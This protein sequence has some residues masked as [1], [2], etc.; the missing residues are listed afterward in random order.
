MKV[1]VATKWNRRAE[2]RE[3]M[4]DLREDGHAITHDWTGEE[5]PGPETDP[6]TRRE[7]YGMCAAADVDG[8]LS[9]EVMVLLHDPACRGAFVELGVALANGTRVIVVDGDG[10][11]EHSV[12]LFY[13]LPEVTHVASA[14][15]AVALVGSMER[16]A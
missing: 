13:F 14:D 12:P 5:D 11:P 8:V 2:A 4:E 1:Y 16:A 9:A 3:V 15:E 6:D 7:F 10:H